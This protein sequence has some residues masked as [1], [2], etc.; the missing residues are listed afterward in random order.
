MRE[1]KRSELR[2]SSDH[3]TRLTPV[4]RVQERRPRKNFR[5]KYSSQKVSTRLLGSGRR[6]AVRG[7]LWWLPSAAALLC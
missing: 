6:R 4:R 5:P 1:R 2:E 3:D 7:V